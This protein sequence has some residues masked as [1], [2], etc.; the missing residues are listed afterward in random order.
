[1]ERHAGLLIFGIQVGSNHIA[2]VNTDSLSGVLHLYVVN[3]TAVFLG[4]RAEVIKKLARQEDRQAV[5]LS[6][7][8]QLD[9]CVNIGGQVTHINFE[10]APDSPFDR[11][12]HMQTKRHLDKKFVAP[13]V[14]AFVNETFVHA[15]VLQLV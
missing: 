10:V 11:P 7:L 3:L 1:M 9:R 12:S 4:L 2:G 5:V 13:L 14:T 15:I 6:R 8:L